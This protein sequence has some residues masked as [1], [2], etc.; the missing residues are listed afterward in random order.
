RLHRSAQSPAGRAIVTRYNDGAVNWAS[1]GRVAPNKCCEDIL[2]AFAYYQRLIAPHSRLFLVGGIKH[3]EAYQFNLARLS[4]HWQLRDVHWLDRV[5]DADGFGAYYALA[6][7]LVEMS[8][9]EGFC[10]PL[11]EAMSFDVPIIAYAAAAVPETLGNAGVQITA[12]RPDTLAGL[13]EALQH[14]GL[15]RSRIITTQRERLAAFATERVLAQLR[16]ALMQ[17]TQGA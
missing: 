13:V 9:H 3:F 12:K 14:D 5:D 17:L 7:V 4:E 6:S 16:A 10:A 11:L 1:V 8:A 2:K 15:L